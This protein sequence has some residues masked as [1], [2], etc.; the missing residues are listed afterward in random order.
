[1]T[2]SVRTVVG[3]TP[4][5][6]TVTETSTQL[7]TTPAGPD[8]LALESGFPLAPTSTTISGQ[9]IDGIQCNRLVQLAYQTYAHL[10]VD[11]RGRPRSLPG[12][13]GL[14]NSS[15]QTT[16]TTTTYAG[17]LCSYWLHTD[18]ADGVVKIDSP[19]PETYTLGDL[20]DIWTEPLTA[21]RVA[22]SRGRVTALVNGRRWHGSPRTIP[23]REHE[24]I[25][26][27]VGRPVPRYVPVNWSETDL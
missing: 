12:A 9:T 20:F 16:G 5:G 7:S 26:L 14:V 10:Q 18:S 13:I 8:G 17:G 4:A 24:T 19:V 11:V 27:A 1:V 3:T 23:L 22:D 15:A 6:E 25:Q 2:T 21:T